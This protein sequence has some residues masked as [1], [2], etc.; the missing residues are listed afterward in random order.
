MT[1][2]IALTG[3]TAID[4]RTGAQH[5]NSTVL[6]DGERIVR[7]GAG[8]A[9][10]VPSE[11][12]IVDA[13]GTWLLPGLMDMHT[14]TTG[15]H[16]AL[17]EKI[18][19]LYLAYGVTTVRDTGGNLTLLRLL[20]DALSDS[21]TTGPRVFFAGPLLDGVPPVWPPCRSSS[22]QRNARAE[23]STFWPIRGWIS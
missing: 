10:E 12:R 6:V 16:N 1:D 15:E 20:R 11:A 7:V 18:L 19:Y 3:G 8:D 5:P 13:S 17:K 14:H 2:V 23:R 21:K 4:V 9:V 22:R